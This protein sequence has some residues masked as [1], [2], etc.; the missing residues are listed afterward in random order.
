MPAGRPAIPV[1]LHLLNGNRRHLTKKEIAER[2][3][4]RV[5]LGEPKLTCPSYVKAD[6]DAY[7]KW[8]EIVKL[9]R[10]IDFVSSADVGVM[11]RY[12]MAFA[13]YLDLVRHRTRVA[14]V[15]VTPEEPDLAVEVLAEKYGTRRAAKL[16]EKI[17][18]ILSVA[19]VI[20][21]DKAIN[22]KM[23]ALVQMEDRLFLNPL[24]KVRNIPKKEKKKEDPLASKGFDNV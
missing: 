17:E 21:L 13:E 14:E 15:H 9:Y 6:K 5:Q 8:R 24:A 1:E 7:K 3:K 11:A 16:Y 20:T 23:A 19:G 2:E 12:C 10:D 4:S 18:Y 22:A